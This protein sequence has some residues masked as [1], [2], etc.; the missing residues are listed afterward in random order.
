VKKRISFI[1]IVLVMLL[2]PQF[3]VLAEGILDEMQNKLIQSR[4]EANEAAAQAT[5]RTLNTA[6]E[7]YRASNAE[8]AYPKTLK[9]L[10]EAQPPY[11]T[12]DLASGTRYG[13]K[14][15]IVNVDDDSYLITAYPESVNSTGRYSFCIKEDSKL[16][17]NQ[18]GSR[19]ESRSECS[20]LP[21]LE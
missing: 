17:I 14:F 16:R 20:N 15:E 6:F 8:P 7:A 1:L 2:T 3:S 13:Y 12:S 18:G 4:M 9:E 10:C 11:I 19:I 21:L 5:L